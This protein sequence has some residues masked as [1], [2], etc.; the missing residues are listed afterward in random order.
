MKATVVPVRRSTGDGRA[1]E[2]S[3]QYIGSLD[4]WRQEIAIDEAEWSTRVPVDADGQVL[5]FLHLSLAG[6]PRSSGRSPLV[7]RLWTSSTTALGAVGAYFML[8]AAARPDSPVFWRTYASIAAFGLFAGFLCIAECTWVMAQTI[9]QSGAVSDSSSVSQGLTDG[10]DGDRPMFTKA[11]TDHQKAEFVWLLLTTRVCKPCAAEVRGWLMKSYVNV[12]PCVAMLWYIFRTGQLSLS[13][14][15]SDENSSTGRLAVAVYGVCIVPTTM[16]LSGWLLYMHVP[17]I[18]VRER[19]SQMVA[20][21]RDMSGDQR[22]FDVVMSMIQDAHESTLRLSALLTPAMV[23]NAC[24]SLTVT[25]FMVVI[26]TLPQPDCH[27]LQVEKPEG[28]GEAEI[29]VTNLT[30]PHA[31]QELGIVVWPWWVFTTLAVVFFIN[32]LIPL[33]SAASTSVAAGELVDAVGR[34]RYQHRANIAACI[35]GNAAGVGQQVKPVMTVPEDL[36]RVNGLQQYAA[37][38][39]GGQ[40]I[41]FTLLKRRIDKA[42]V[43]GVMYRGLFLIGVF[44]ACMR[45]VVAAS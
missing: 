15:R 34:L 17:C 24:L 25:S 44:I 37:E 31:W 35:G 7:V 42:W 11:L 40:G 2:R 3:V 28:C 38:L 30:V 16:I 23:V 14:L 4:A 39:N 8:G 41:G 27:R 33:L 22:N 19:I 26:S 21:V 1:M 36:I 32:I 18:I 10:G 9:P 6:T 43:V 29:G 20:A 12:F 5:K 45:L 13:E